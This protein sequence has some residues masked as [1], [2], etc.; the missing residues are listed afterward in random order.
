M[1]ESYCTDSTRFPYPS[2]M[3][4]Q[5]PPTTRKPRRPPKPSFSSRPE[6]NPATDLQRLFLAVPLPQEV[7]DFVDTIVRR[8]GHE[9]WPVRWTAAGNAHITLHF[10]GEIEPERAELLRL[11]L[12]EVVAQHDHFRLRTADLGVFPNMKRPRVVWLGLWGPAHRLHTLRDAIGETLES[13]EYEL[14]DKEFHPHITL[15]RIRDPRTNR[16]RDLPGKI[17]VRIEQAAQ[18]GEVTHEQPRQ[19]PVDEVLLVQSHLGGREGSRYEVL[20]RFPLNIPTPRRRDQ[21]DD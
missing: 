13:L 16:I 17:R 2:V 4:D 1:A 6:P 21:P 3:T 12:P 11:A 18:T 5:A 19:V 9:G 15:G 8:L 14:D 7:I 10:L 20:E